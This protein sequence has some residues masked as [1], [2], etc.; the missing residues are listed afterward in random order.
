MKFGSKA[1]RRQQIRRHLENRMRIAAETRRFFVERGF[2]EVETPIRIPAPAPETHVDCVEASGAFLQASPELAMKEILASGYDRI[3]QLARC[4][5]EK[6]RG[7]RHLPEMTLLEWY[8]KHEDYHYMMAE[9]EALFCRLAKNLGK[10]DSFFWQGEEISLSLPFHRLTVAEA[11]ERHASI[12]LKEALAKN[13]FNET[14]AFEVEPFLGHEKPLF[15]YEYPASEASLAR[16][17]PE[18]SDFAERFE[19]YVAGI[20]L[21]NAYTELTGPVEQ[22]RRFRAAMEERRKLG[23]KVYPFPDVFLEALEFMPMATGNALGFD[24]LCMLLSDTPDLDHLTAV[25]PEEL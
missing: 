23:K 4:F 21:C 15:L 8:V 18:D 20:E 17:K 22:E 12:S 3:F 6:E 10:H 11:F 9:T 13:L 25:L 14:L 19:L 16:L 1:F 2:L 7:Q 5:R 24:R